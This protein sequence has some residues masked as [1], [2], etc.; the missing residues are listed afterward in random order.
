MVKTAIVTGLDIAETQKNAIVTICIEM[1][2]NRNE[3][4]STK[5]CLVETLAAALYKGYLSDNPKLA[6]SVQTILLD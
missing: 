6:A 5:Q 1:L 4:A 3:S 2:H